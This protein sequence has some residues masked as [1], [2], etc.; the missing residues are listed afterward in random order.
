MYTPILHA[1]LDPQELEPIRYYFMNIVHLCIVVLWLTLFTVC[2]EMESS[3]YLRTKGV[4]EVA[5]YQWHKD[6]RHSRETLPFHRS[7]SFSDGTQQLYSR[8]VTREQ[9]VL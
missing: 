4:C 7:L 1:S 6:R 9:R 2:S 5:E 3:L 8:P